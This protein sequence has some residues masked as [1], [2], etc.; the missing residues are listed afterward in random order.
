MRASL[1]PLPVAVVAEF[2]LENRTQHLTCRLLDYS[3]LD[4]RNAQHSFPA[5]RLRYRYASYRSRL[6]AARSQSLR[7]HRPVFS[8]VVC[9]ANAHPIHSR[10]SFVSFYSLISFLR[11]GP[12][13]GFSH[14]IFIQHLPF[15]LRPSPA[16]IPQFR[17]ARGIHH[18]LLVAK[19][20][21]AAVATFACFGIL[22][23]VSWSCSNGLSFGSSALRSSLFP[24]LLHYYGF[25]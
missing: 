14:H 21:A 7:Y 16:C 17:S 9:E 4:I 18:R 20:M 22:P 12:I 8:G 1:R 3:V 2:R 10:R 19:R 25:C 23:A 15:L 13:Q 11:V 5:L 24:C 6:I